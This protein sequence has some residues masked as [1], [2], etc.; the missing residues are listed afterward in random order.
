MEFNGMRELDYEKQIWAGHCRVS[1][2]WLGVHVTTDK[3][4]HLNMIRGMIYESTSHRFTK[5]SEMPAKLGE[6][7]ILSDVVGELEKHSNLL[8]TTNIVRKTTRKELDLKLILYPNLDIPELEVKDFTTRYQIQLEVESN[9]KSATFIL[10]EYEGKRFFGPSA[11]DLFNRTGQNIECSNSN[12]HDNSSSL[13]SS[14][15]E[16]S[17]ASSH[18]SISIS[19][20]KE[21]ASMPPDN[22]LKRKMPLA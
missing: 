8:T 5:A 7:L 4:L 20:A 18:K 22:K 2:L 9:S 13:L 14:G 19:T 17:K 15:I 1:R 6:I 11:N 12:L 21:S 3:V 10:F 16:S